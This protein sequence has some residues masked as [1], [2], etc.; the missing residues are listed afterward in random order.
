MKRRKFLRLG[1]ATAA[2]LLLPRLF[3]GD[4]DS[5]V[6]ATTDTLE[7]PLWTPSAPA[8][9]RSK[10]QLLAICQLRT[11]AWAEGTWHPG[12]TCQKWTPGSLCDPYRIIFSFQEFES[13]KDHP[14]RCITFIDG[15]GRRN[16]SDA[17]GSYQFLSTTYDS[18]VQHHRR[19]FNWDLKEYFSPRNQDVAACFT[20]WDIGS[21]R[22]IMNAAQTQNGRVI[23]PDSAI[24]RWSAH[25]ANTWASLPRHD[26]DTAGAHNQ[27]AKSMSRVVEMFQSTLRSLQV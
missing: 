8:G 24:K 23:I 4:K 9:S 2:G 14:R 26:E 16:C 12:K 27:G 3:Q 1:V 20:L 25:S 21:Y 6:L 5:P 15:Y 10:G 17:A 18:C 19:N 13:F 7:N 22:I 11:I